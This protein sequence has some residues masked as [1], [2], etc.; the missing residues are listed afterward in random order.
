MTT[1]ALGSS[2]VF[3]FVANIVDR[4]DFVELKYVGIRFFSVRNVEAVV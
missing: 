1:T 3:F 2:H 4:A